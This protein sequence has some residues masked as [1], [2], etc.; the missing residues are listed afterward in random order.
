MSDRHEVDVNKLLK[1]SDKLVSNC[2]KSEDIYSL[3]VLALASVTKYSRE[4]HHI[5]TSNRI[6][7][8]IAFAPDLIQY[9]V[10]KKIITEGVGSMLHKQYDRRKD[11][12]PLILQSYIISAPALYS[13][14]DT[15]KKKSSCMF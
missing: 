12:F 8:T 3:L 9:L 11:E 15:K 2:F 1:L 7:L 6:D 5:N 14:T 13:K 4:I 10:R